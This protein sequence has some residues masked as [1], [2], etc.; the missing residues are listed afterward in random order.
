MPA[1]LLLGLIFSLATVVIAVLTGSEKFSSIGMLLLLVAVFILLF[2]HVLP[3][4]IVR[5]NPEKVLAVILPP[6]DFAARFL[7]PLTGNLVRL[8]ADS[9]RE[10]EATPVVNGGE[11]TQREDAQAE[12]VEEQALIE[13]VEQK[14]LQSIVD[15]G[16]TLVREVMTPG[17]TSSRFP[18]RSR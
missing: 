11:E 5:R 1:R 9:R 18:P 8:I 16:D 14:L 3:L 6:F 12:P 4:F 15:F 13:R 10:R 17:P 7:H 2:E